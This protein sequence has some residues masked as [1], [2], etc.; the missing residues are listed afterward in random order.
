[1]RAQC[2]ICSDLFEDALT[3]NIAALHCGHTFHETC[4]MRWMDT[5]S[6]CPSCRTTVKPNQ[7][8][9]RLYF[10]IAEDLNGN[11]DIS[12]FIN[13]IGNLKVQLSE[14]D[15]QK[16]DLADARDKLAIRLAQSESLCESLT[17][18]LNKELSIKEVMQ[19][20]IQLL[21]NENAVFVDDMKEFRKTQKKLEA[22]QNL[23]IVLNGCED[24]VKQVMAQYTEGG[25]SSLKQ[26]A[27]MITVM[28][29][30]YSKVLNDKKGLLE[31]VTKLKQ[32][33]G[34]YHTEARKL[35]H[36]VKELAA[37]LE[38]ANEGLTKVEKENNEKRRKLVHLRNALRH[39][40]T[41]G[42]QSFNQALNEDS[43]NVAYTPPHQH[44][45][46][47]DVNESSTPDLFEDSVVDNKRKH[48]Y[49]H[50]TPKL[51]FIQ[52]P[53]ATEKLHAAKRAKLELESQNDPPIPKTML[54]IM[55]KKMTGISNSRAHLPSVITRGYD[56]FGGST[57]F[58][59][60]L[61]PPKASHTK[62]VPKNKTIKKSKFCDPKT[63]KNMPLFKIVSKSTPCSSPASDGGVSQQPEATRVIQQ[64]QPTSKSKSK[65]CASTDN[66]SSTLFP[67]LSMGDRDYIDLT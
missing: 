33:V 67:K 55:Q 60:P 47:T 12:K 27:S 57:T 42:S 6:T 30:E 7:I 21:Q 59:Q 32:S 8:I 56:G 18:K 46:L 16:Q 64:T 39:N 17:I 35:K 22:L 19:R 58:V 20:N 41:E 40:I 62:I 37:E 52:I 1:M 36:K 28:K 29:R 14:K 38:R 51:K 66:H 13:Q 3:V 63:F 4:L 65:S 15:R 11:E 24:D 34:N 44:D 61:G 48:N 9:K 54:S 10:D 43:P 23:E 31:K 25:E 53:T 5:S 45:P 50:S 2:C 26:L 49:D